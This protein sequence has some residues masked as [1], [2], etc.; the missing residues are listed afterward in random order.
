MIRKWGR[1]ELPMFGPLLAPLY[2]LR[3]NA[4]GVEFRYDMNYRRFHFSSL[5]DGRRARELLGYVPTHPLDWPTSTPTRGGGRDAG[6]AGSR[7]KPPR[8]ARLIRECAQSRSISKRRSARASTSARGNAS[9][10]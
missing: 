1:T 7:A 6:R 9:F 3:A 10:R 8:T 2:R 4:L 5:P